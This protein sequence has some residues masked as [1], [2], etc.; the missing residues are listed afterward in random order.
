MSQISTNDGVSNSQEK[1]NKL[2]VCWFCVVKANLQQ[3]KIKI[4]G[5]MKA[6]GIYCTKYNLIWFEIK[7]DT[8][9]SPAS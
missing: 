6:L 4:R 3:L 7:L 8:I 9:L 5:Q 1:D 2:E